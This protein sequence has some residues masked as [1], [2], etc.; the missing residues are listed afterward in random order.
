V[1]ESFLF[2]SFKAQRE[3]PRPPRKPAGVGKA[4]GNGPDHIFVL[5]VRDRAEHTADVQLKNLDAAHP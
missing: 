2:E 1:G 3:L 4:R 5:L